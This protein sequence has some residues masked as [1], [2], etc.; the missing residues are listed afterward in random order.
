MWL[1]LKTGSKV[2]DLM[3]SFA[4]VQLEEIERD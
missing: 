3:V 4:Y 2:Y 1:A